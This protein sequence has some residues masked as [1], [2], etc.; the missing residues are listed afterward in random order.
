MKPIPLLLALSLATLSIETPIFSRA[1]EIPMD[2]TQKNKPVTIKVLLQEKEPSLLLEVKGP[3]K[4]FC[5]HTDI[6]LSSS[7]SA[8]RAFITPSSNGL[9]WGETLP[10]NQALR[11][12][13]SDNKTSIFVNGIQYK[14]CLEVYDLGGS[15]RAI[16]E[17]D[18]ENYLKSCL[19]TSFFDVEEPEVLNALTIVLRTQTYHQI[20]KDPLAAWH[21][22]AVDSGYRGFAITF[23]NVA[24]EKAINSTRHAVLTYNAKP[25]ATGWTE[26]SAGVTASFSSV[27]KKNSPSPKGVK[28]AGMEAERLKS[29]WSFQVAKDQLATIAKL[30]QVSS[31]SAFSEK[32]SGKVYAVK[33][34]DGSNIKTLDFFAL[35]EALGKNKL[36]SNDFTI[37]VLDNA[38]RFKGYGEGNGVG[39]CLHSATLMAKQGLD[40]KT[41]LSKFFEEASLEK[42]EKLPSN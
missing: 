30:A 24:I 9:S 12:V 35:Q 29:A 13:P 32:G 38:I 7:S 4:I 2:P 3:Y 20:Q 34:N 17:S 1:M 15:L 41:I 14:G 11:I 28:I 26:N 23:Q 16:I 22:T 25:F 8:K 40:A 42:M 5:P 33:I 19:A 27:F 10:G 6:L 31:A 18:V 21:T 36:K 37:E 39:L